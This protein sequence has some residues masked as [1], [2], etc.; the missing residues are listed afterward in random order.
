MASH[1]SSVTGYLLEV[2]ILRWTFNPAVLTKVNPA[3]SA[4]VATPSEPSVPPQYAV[5]DL[6]QICSDME[7]IKILQKGHGEWAEAMV[8]VGWLLSTD[9]IQFSLR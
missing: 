8:P 2:L 7:R 3:S 6:V 9:S 4:A 5:G 1:I